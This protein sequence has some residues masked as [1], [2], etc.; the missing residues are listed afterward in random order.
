M[1]AG[2][3]W[4]RF[5]FFPNQRSN[6]MFSISTVRKCAILATF[7]I[8]GL[9][10][11]QSFAEHPTTKPAADMSQMDPAKMMEM[12]QKLAEPG[13]EHKKIAEMAGSWTAEIH[14]WM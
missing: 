10:G 13:P 3:L 2:V 8:V 11:L 14:G 6:S 5:P 1:P 12:M 9:V 4:G 7:G